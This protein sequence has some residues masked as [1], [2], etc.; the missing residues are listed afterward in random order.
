MPFLILVGLSLTL[1]GAF[2]LLTVVEAKYGRVFASS[3]LKLDKRV[4]RVVFIV[5]HVDWG[6]FIKHVVQATIERVAHDTA[7][8]TLV[9][10]RFIERSLTRL[11]M[12][13][14]ERRSGR[15]TPTATS[16]Q[17]VSLRETL[18]SFRKSL[19]ERPKK[20]LRKGE[21]SI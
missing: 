5:Q 12:T 16:R 10:T 21:E 9:F 18:E 3:R 14:R 8:A 4:A 1:F 13:L 17:R 7:H 15:T 6:G 20:K 2:L 19:H 11:V